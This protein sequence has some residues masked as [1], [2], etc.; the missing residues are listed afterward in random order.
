[1]VAIARSVFSLRRMITFD[2][3]GRGREKMAEAQSA[4]SLSLPLFALSLS[5]HLGGRALIVANLI[6]ACAARPS[7]KGAKFYA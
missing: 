6:F 4:P 5:F 2:L 1:M 7:C 3:E